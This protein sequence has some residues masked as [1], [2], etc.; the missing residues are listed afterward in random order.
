MISE[1]SVAGAVCGGVILAA[2]IVE[3]MSDRWLRNGKVA[4]HGAEPIICPD[5]EMRDR[6]TRIETEVNGLTGEVRAG[7]KRIE[8]KIDGLP[9]KR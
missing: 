6:V 8:S 2:K 7:F 9:R 3:K 1:V 4:Q 5:P